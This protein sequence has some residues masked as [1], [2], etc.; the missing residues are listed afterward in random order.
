MKKF[1]SSFLDKLRKNSIKEK[2]LEKVTSCEVEV[3]RT[4]TVALEVK[5]DSEAISSDAKEIMEVSSEIKVCSEKYLVETQKL[6]KS[7]QIQVDDLRRHIVRNETLLFQLNNH[8]K[9]KKLKRKIGKGE[10]IKA[11][12]VS[13]I[14]GQF[15]LENVIDE[16]L[17]NHND[18]FEVCV[19]IRYPFDKEFDFD[20]KQY[21]QLVECH[22]YYESKCYKSILG[23][24]I[25]KNPIELDTL[26]PDIVLYSAYSIE[27][28]STKHNS[29]PINWS[30][31][32]LTCFFNYGL[33]TDED[34]FYHYDHYFIITNWINFL[35]TQKDM[36][37]ASVRSIYN[38]YN[39]TVA[40]FPKLDSYKIEK[41]FSFSSSMKNCIIYSPHW[42]VLTTENT[43]KISGTFHLYYEYFL[44]LLVKN[45]D[46]NFVF[47]PHPVLRNR[48]NDLKREKILS[49]DFDDYVEKLSQ[50]KNCIYHCDDEYIEVF[51]KSKCLITDCGSFI[52]EYLPS[53]HPCIYLFNPEVPDQINRFSH[54]GKAILD[55]YYIVHNEEELSD[56]FQQVV[57]DGFD[58]KKEARERVM[59]SEFVN[60]GTAS[61]VVIQTIKEKLEIF[62]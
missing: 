13:S 44:M 39:C 53:G 22:N 34:F 25:N 49:I 52:G 27:G 8:E 57:K 19:F 11:V 58:P 1:L 38:A 21:Q 55:S 23:Y 28:N 7:L 60:I 48:L 31:N 61:K 6:S 42:S 16:L 40:G 37:E 29:L 4:A 46:L 41:Q 5:K 24:D 12:F 30:H 51:K 14:V 45:P 9:V 50:Y 3:R 20:E 62:D 2:I 59:K 18:L 56:C 36:F 17:E 26:T 43:A 32:Y 15:G 54:L 10:K 47:R 33:N 35:H